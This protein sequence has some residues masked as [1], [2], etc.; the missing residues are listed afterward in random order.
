MLFDLNHWG[1]ISQVKNKIIMYWLAENRAASKSL[2]ST[3]RLRRCPG[4]TLTELLVVIAIIAILAGMLLP[5]LSRAKDR[6]QGA[7]C[8][9]NTK[10]IGLAVIMYAGDQEDYFP[11]IDPSWTAGP[12]VNARGLPCG[13]EWNLKT[14]KPNT[15]APLLQSY[16][17]N[18]RVWVCPKRKR[19]F[20]Y[21]SESGSWEPSITGFLSYGFNELG[22]FG[23]VTPDDAYRL[24][25]FRTS[26]TLKP[27]ET[28]AVADSSG[29]NDPAECFPGGQANDYKGDAAWLD[30]VWA[31]NSGPGQPPKGKNHRLQTAYAKH[32]KRVNVIYVDGHAASSLASHCSV[33]S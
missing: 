5:A 10:Q 1:R 21:K 2:G 27:S 25:K 16:A 30:L 7:G 4:F 26:N 32:N 29:S 9:S 6:A 17:P 28:V 15:I 12:F 3:T 33:S 19:G 8:L 23:R 31:S 20:T 13:G 18:N 22:V 14:G 24:L 11:Q